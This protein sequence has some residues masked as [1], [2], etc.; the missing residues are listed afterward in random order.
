MAKKPAKKAAKANPAKLEGLAEGS[1]STIQQELTAANE[2]FARYKEKG[3]KACL[4]RVRKHLMN[5]KRAASDGRKNVQ[6]V[7]NS[8]K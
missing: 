4:G 3:T 6:E 5:I 1:L 7:R 2:E 8:L